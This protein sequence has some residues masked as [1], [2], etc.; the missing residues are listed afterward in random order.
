MPT[1]KFEAMDTTGG[2]VKD[3]IDAASEEEAQQKIRQMGYFVTRLTEVAEK[4]K[5]K[6]KKK[7]GK[8]GQQYVKNRHQGT[9]HTTT[10]CSESAVLRAAPLASASIRAA[11]HLVSE[12][13][14]ARR[15]RPRP[16]RRSGS[17]LPGRR[18]AP[19]LVSRGDVRR[20][21]QAVAQRPCDERSCDL[22]AVAVALPLRCDD[23]RQRG[24]TAGDGRL[25]SAHGPAVGSAADRPVEPARVT[26]GPRA[27]DQAP[28][29]RLQ[30]WLAER[31]AADELV[32]R[33]VVEQRGELAASP[34]AAGRGAGRPRAASRAQGRRSPPTPS[35]HFATVY[36]PQRRVGVLGADGARVEHHE[37]HA[38]RA[39]FHRSS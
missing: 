29:A 18:P 19:S 25:R 8:P 34:T 3:S 30:L 10:Y 20:G 1:Y 5:K 36:G 32:Q 15:V 2:E 33:G 22:A 27:G 37:R 28:V 26:V 9:K 12:P 35:R 21:L 7:G 24:L 6:G 16:N 11:F 4:D 13:V 23:P 31:P 38:R 17:G 14:S 39:G